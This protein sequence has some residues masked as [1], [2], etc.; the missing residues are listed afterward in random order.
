[1]YKPTE[2]IQKLSKYYS[3]SYDLKCEIHKRRK[4]NMRNY[5]DVALEILLELEAKQIHQDKNMTI[6]QKEGY[7]SKDNYFETLSEE[8]DIDKSIIY[9][10]SDLLGS[11]E[12][13]DGLI[14]SIQDYCGI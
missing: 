2:V 5:L 13:F 6:Y 14:C 4:N 9:A 3:N 1:M 10:L 8:Y 7:E 12:D 11:N